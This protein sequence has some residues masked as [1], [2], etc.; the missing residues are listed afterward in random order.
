M[1]DLR[2]YGI[3]YMRMKMVNAELGLIGIEFN[4]HHHTIRS[5]RG[6]AVLNVEEVL[7]LVVNPR[8]FLFENSTEIME[9]WE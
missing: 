8:K 7:E 5:K 3:T 6:T 1:E 9:R 4:V 2:D